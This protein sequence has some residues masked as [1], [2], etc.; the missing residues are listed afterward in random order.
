MELQIRPASPE[1]AE[2]VAL[3][4]RIT[5]FETFGHLFLDHAGDLRTYLDHTF[6]VAKI[7]GSLGDPDNRYWLSLL[8]GLPVGYAKLKFPSPTV[9]LPEDG[10]AQL[11]KIYVLR[12]FLAQG[13]G[14]VLLSVAVDNAAKRGLNTVWLDVLKQ[15][16][17]AIRFYEREGFAPLGDDT[18]T[19]GA[20][21]FE[22]HLMA[23]RG[24]VG[25]TKRSR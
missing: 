12:E 7:R 6:A 2:V 16:S 3:L 11:Q 8:N 4:G 20:Q 9:L 22:F 10:P 18:Y 19:I 17:R 15:N 13:I 14:K 1:D 21:T 23:V 5:F 24:V 25:Q